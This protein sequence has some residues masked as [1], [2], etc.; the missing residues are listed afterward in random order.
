[1]NDI[2]TADDKIQA[3]NLVT[4]PN[5]P[6]D[7]M[8]MPGMFERLELM[9][10]IMAKSRAMVP[11]FLQGNSG[12]CMAVVMKAAQWRMD[13]YSVASKA[14][15]AV[16]GGPIG[17]EAQLISA[18]IIGNAP[19]VGRP[20]Y[21]FFGDWSKIQGN[22]KIL[23]SGKGKKYAAGN[24]ADKDEEGVG[25]TVSITLSDTDETLSM[26]VLLKQ[27]FPRNSTNWAND[28]QQ[29]ICYRAIQI[30][31]RRHFP[32]VALGLYTRDEMP[33]AAERDMGSAEVVKDV[34]DLLQGGATNTKKPET[35]EPLYMEQKIVKTTL[36][37]FESIDVTKEQVE[38]RLGHIADE[39][40]EKEY[41]DLRKV[42]VQIATDGKPIGDF[43]PVILEAPPVLETTQLVQMLNSADS[44]ES[45]AD[46][47]E[48][49]KNM[50]DQEEQDK[51]SGMLAVRREELS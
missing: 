19:I 18:V 20:K 25:V 51:L 1:M 31:A 4:L 7:L 46:I 40:T 37:A 33:V 42:Y 13:P 45:L 34:S 10:E 11:K 3:T 21:D 41:L 8:F 17:Y 35:M 6:G 15:Q 24:W 44:L 2:T 14:Y 39:M 12:D 49:V 30:M 29:Q 9:A 26:D 16:Q 38:E 5:S 43:F 22:V 23:T 47:E 48:L 28:P 32:D 36:A 27:C 50:P